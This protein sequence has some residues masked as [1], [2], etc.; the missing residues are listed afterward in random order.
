ML[1]SNTRGSN[2]PSSAENCLL[3]YAGPPAWRFPFVLKISSEN[4]FL[5][6][7]KYELNRERQTL[8]V[9]TLWIFIIKIDI[10]SSHEL[11]IPSPVNTHEY[12]KHRNQPEMVPLVRLQGS[13]VTRGCHQCHNTSQRGRAKVLRYRR[14][15][16]VMAISHTAGIYRFQCFST[17]SSYINLMTQAQ[18]YS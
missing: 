15:D 11:R 13:E 18:K 12:S 6:N 14:P 8:K 5:E 10:Q 16:I 17:A 3:P 7:L 4:S 9:T 1:M 2:I